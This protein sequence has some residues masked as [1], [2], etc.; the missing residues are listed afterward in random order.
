MTKAVE[1]GMP[2]LRIEEAAARRQA[3]VD[4]GEEVVVGV[5]KYRRRAT[6]SWSTSST[7]T[8]PR[9]AR[10]RSPGSSSVRA[11]A[12]RG[13]RAEAALEALTEG[14]RG[15]RQPARARAST[16]PGPGPPSARSPTRMEEVFGRHR[17]EI[18]TH[19]RRVRRGLRGRRG[20]RR[21]PG[22]RST[23]SPRREG[24]RP[25]HA[26]REAGPGRPRPRRQGDRHRLR[27]PRLRRRRRPAVPDAGRGGR[28]TRSRT[29]CTS[30]ACRARPPGTRRS[31]PQLIDELR[32]A[33]R[34]R[35][36]RRVRRRDPAAGLRLPARRRRGRR[37]RPRHQHPEGRGRGPRPRP[38]APPRRVTRRRAR[39]PTAIRAG[40]RRALARAITLVESTRADHRERGGRAARRAARRDRRRDPR[41]HQRPAG[42]R[43]VDVHRGASACTSIERRPPASRCWPSTRR[44]RRSGGSILGD[45]T[46]METLARDPTAFIRPSPVGR[47]ARRRRPPHPRGDA[48]VRGRRLRR[49]ARRDRRRRP[50]RG[51]G[52]RHGRPVRA[53][54]LARRRR[55]AA[56][57][58]ARDHGARRPGRGHQG[59]RRRWPPRPAHACADIRN[60]L[61]LLRPHH[62]ELPPR[63]CS[64]RRPRARAWPRCGRPSPRRTRRC[65][66]PVPSTGCGPRRPGAGCGR[67]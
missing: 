8:T 52:R 63:R 56:G 2:K 57:H 15:R 50:V 30:S 33:G 9:C 44:A 4:R 60:A 64:C 18:R 58:Q 19:L 61:H 6:P 3:R 65:A 17:A 49:R 47:R 27:R 45:K 38:R 66:R 20:L 23:R 1:S 13:R 12:R 34:R 29:T 51:R 59:R 41:R 26:R 39:S 62:A 35:R 48:A 31:C 16:R 53:A 28:A 43:Q 25:A 10:S 37:V 21:G 7:S 42:R 54:R 24:R 22:A 36:A 5:N 32:Q 14:R 55:R 46:R 67:R 11:D 40:D